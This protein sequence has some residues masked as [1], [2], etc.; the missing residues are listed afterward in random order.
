MLLNNKKCH[1]CNAYYDPTLNECPQCH[2]ENELYTNRQLSDSVMYYHPIA[3]IGLFL[4][5]FS[6][7]GM[8]VSGFIVALV[9]YGVDDNGL[10]G[11]LV[12]L[13]TYL[14]ML[15]ALM[16]ISF[17]SR[18]RIFIKKFKRPY[19]YLFGLAYAGGIV[20][21]GWIIGLITGIFYKDPNVNQQTAESLITNYPII[22][23]FV[24]CIL[25]PICEELTY[26]VGLYSFLR[27]INK[28]LALIVTM[29]VFAM[30]HFTFEAENIVEEL[31]SLPSYLISGLL[32][33][34]AYELRGPACSITAHACY[35]LIAIIM[36]MVAR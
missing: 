14:L 32:L 24:I 18:E 26:R 22:A 3:Q 25:G 7:V 15:S 20:L 5:G 2:K 27:R 13:F 35:N 10:R 1:N 33:T 34:L 28:Y 31:W 36:I 23:A 9:P 11:A 21:F 17:T 30:I 12:I 6:Y 19:D 16:T 4:A 8:L 29:V